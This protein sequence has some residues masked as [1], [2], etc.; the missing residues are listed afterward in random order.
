MDSRRSAM[1]NSPLWSPFPEAPDTYSYATLGEL[2]AWIIGWDLIIEYAVGNVAV[3]ISWANYFKTFV[4]GFGLIIPDW[5]ST[6]FRTARKIPGLL[7]CPS[8]VRCAD[9]LQPSFCRHRCVNH[10]CAGS[11]YTRELPHQ[12]GHGPHQTSRSVILRLRRHSL[13]QTGKLDTS[14]RMAGRGFRP[15]PPSSS[16]RI[17][18][19]TRCRRPP[20]RSATQSGTSRS[21]LSDRLSFARLSI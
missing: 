10:D 6:D 1:R 2:V 13:C 16:S 8:S 14:L 18:D 11:W 17:S 21:A 20:R 9:R 15:G 19:L 3:A 4:A 7:G 12:H 5:F